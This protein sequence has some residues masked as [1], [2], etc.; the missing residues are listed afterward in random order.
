MVQLVQQKS[1]KWMLALCAILAYALALDLFFV[2]GGIISG[3]F[4]GFAMMINSFFPVSIG[5]LLFLLNVP[6]LIVSFF[7]KGKAYTIST[8]ILT[9]L[10]SVVVDA[11]AFL[12]QITTNRFLA[13]IFGGVLYGIGSA[14]LVKARLSTGGSD[15]FAKLM[16]LKYKNLSLGKMYLCIDGL[17]I[18]FSIIVY[19]D[20]ENCLYAILAIYTYVVVTDHI[21]DIFNN[22][23]NCVIICDKNTEELSHIL[24][25]H[26]GRGMTRISGMGMY[27]KEEKSIFFFTV[28]PYE[29]ADVRKLVQTHVPN[30]FMMVEKVTE[31]IGSG[32]ENLNDENTTTI[33]FQKQMDILRKEK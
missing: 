7:L 9:F 32:F 23:C 5:V 28:R 15:L 3:G 29:V 12:P 16:L 14:L 30:A 8:L 2:H 21:I 25:G 4:V 18:A 20:L 11:L 24:L 19:Q 26:F 31:V 33:Q 1:K 22:A 10:F 17:V 6:C 27:T 13:A